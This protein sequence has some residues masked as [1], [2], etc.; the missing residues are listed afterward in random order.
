MLGTCP[1]KNTMKKDLSTKWGT[2]NQWTGYRLRTDE[3]MR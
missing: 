3:D 1:N 2:S